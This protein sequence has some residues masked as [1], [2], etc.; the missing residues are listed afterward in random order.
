MN[1]F[2][3]IG[4]RSVI[5]SSTLVDTSAAE[6]KESATESAPVASTGIPAK[7]RHSCSAAVDDM[8]EIEVHELLMNSADITLDLLS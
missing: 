5:A 2:E 3:L 1:I 8:S 7:G 6:E 4:K